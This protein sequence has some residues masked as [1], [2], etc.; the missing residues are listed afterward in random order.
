M[1]IG[2]M[3]H[4]YMIMRFVAS[5]CAV[6]PSSY[7]VPTDNIETPGN[8]GNIC[9]CLVFTGMIEGRLRSYVWMKTTIQPSSML[10][11][12]KL[13]VILWLVYGV[14]NET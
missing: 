8:S 7:N 11:P 12:M 2:K 3:Q 9:I 6:Q 5:K 4:W 13:E 1:H 10:T 14:S